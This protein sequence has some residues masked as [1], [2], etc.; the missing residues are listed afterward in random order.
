MSNELMLVES[1]TMREEIV[2]KVSDEKMD[3]IFNKV[4]GLVLLQDDRIATTEMV[5]NYYETTE[6]AIRQIIVRHNDELKSD[7][8]SVLIGKEL[9]DIKSLCQI[10]SRA[11]S[12]TI[13]PR[14]AILRLGMLLRDSIVAKQV[15][16]YLLDVEGNTKVE[17]KLIALTQETN[18]TIILL[19][20]DILLL[21]KDNSVIITDNEEL[22]HNIVMLINKVDELL[23]QPLFKIH[24]NSSRTYDMLMIEFLSAMESINIRNTYSNNY[25][26]FNK[27][28]E[29]WTGIDFGYK[30]INKKQYWI[31]YYGIE[32]IRQF[33]LGV[34]QGII[35]KNLDGNW[36]SKS[37]IYSN[38]VE[39]KKIL[40]S[41]DNKCA[42]C[43]DDGILLAEHIAP[44]SSNGGTDILYNIIP[45]CNFCNDRKGTM[46]MKNWLDIKMDEGMTKSDAQKIRDHWQKYHIK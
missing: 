19:Q 46:D 5:A 2:V 10:E 37:G 13:L 40:N 27:E 12:L 11:K 42:Y 3:E 8:L 16:T 20:K 24:E 43:G 44:Q 17:D 6:D 15:R 38:K 34:K 18:N 31:S 23:E 9:S 32:N 35:V 41:F 45:S 22:K 36:V 7:G 4:K 39:W 14:R 21:K 29:N 1:K 25:T 26:L 33:I 28:F 30:K